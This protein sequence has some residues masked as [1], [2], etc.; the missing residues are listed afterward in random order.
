[1]T[2]TGNKD[3]EPPSDKDTRELTSECRQSS[4]S[5]KVCVPQ[6]LGN[7][8]S[9]FLHTILEEPA[10]TAELDNAT[11]LNKPILGKLSENIINQLRIIFPYHTSSDLENFI[12]EVNIKNRNKLSTDAYL[13]RLTEFILD[14]PNT[15][16]VLSSSGK[17]EKL[18]SCTSGKNGSHTQKVLNTLVQSKPKSKAANEKKNKTNFPPQSNQMPWKKIGE[19]S[20]S[21]WKKSNDALD[22][23]PC[24]ICHEELTSNL[25]H[26]LDCGHRF[27]K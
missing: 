4:L 21:K 20:K 8:G 9:H 2:H 11:I 24:V 19:T 13:N 16:K 23:D 22:N 1:K 12:K 27:H 10:G 26:V 25:L 18:S 3:P 5:D 14:H 6:S 15:K 17:N 7:S